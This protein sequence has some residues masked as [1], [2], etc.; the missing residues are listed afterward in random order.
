MKQLH[1]LPKSPLSKH[2]CLWFS[3]SLSPYFLGAF[4]SIPTVRKK[5]CCSFVHSFAAFNYWIE[6][7][8]ISVEGQQ[9]NLISELPEIFLE[10]LF[11]LANIEL[12]RAATP[13]LYSHCLLIWYAWKVA[14]KQQPDFVA[15]AILRKGWEP[16]W[17]IYKH[18]E[19][20]GQMMVVRI[21]KYINN[22]VFF[23]PESDVS[24]PR[25]HSVSATVKSNGKKKPHKSC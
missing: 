8:F 3:W 7:G 19:E 1:H 4:F 24:M 9:N 23:P 22:W 25:C 13:P 16:G 12:G 10:L 11:P 6:F 15:K 14:N 5:K 17:R 21:I 2:I 18:K 20:A